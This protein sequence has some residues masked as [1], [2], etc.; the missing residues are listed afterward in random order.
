MSDFLL[1]NYATSPRIVEDA[2]HKSLGKDM[3]TFSWIYLQNDTELYK[4]MKLSKGH[5]CLQI[6]ERE[7]LFWG[8]GSKKWT[9]N[10]PTDH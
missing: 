6:H 7:P 4:D 3:N 5:Q 9:V 8:A 1:D 2:Q 10:Q